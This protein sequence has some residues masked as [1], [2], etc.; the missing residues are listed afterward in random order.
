MLH[1][2]YCVLRTCVSIIFFFFFF[3]QAEDGIRDKLV[4]GVQTCALPIFA[5][6]V[7]PPLGLP[8]GAIAIVE[9]RR[10]VGIG[11]HVHAAACAAVAAV[12][13]AFGD[14]LFATKGAG[15]GAACAPN[16]LD[17]RSVDEH[18]RGTRNA[19]RGTGRPP[20]R[21]VRIDAMVMATSCF[22]SSRSSATLAEDRKSVV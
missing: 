14:E 16:D 2:L 3:F 12:G 6:A 21:A 13:T 11:A 17:D 22:A 10:E 5:L 20:S 15:A 7:L 18:Q 4:T 19:E 8:V 1:L 9:Q